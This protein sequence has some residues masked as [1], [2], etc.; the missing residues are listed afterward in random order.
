M[1]KVMAIILGA[2]FSIHC[3]DSN[4]KRISVQGTSE[5]MNDAV[6]SI[7]KDHSEILSANIIDNGFSLNGVIPGSDFYD[8]QIDVNSSPP[9]SKSYLMFLDGEECHISFANGGTGDYPVIES[10]SQVQKDISRFY[11]LYETKKKAIEKR[12]IVEQ[13]LV[14]RLQ[15]KEGSLLDF[16]NAVKTSNSSLLESVGLWDQSREVFI[17]QNSTSEL[18]AY[19]MAEMANAIEY[20]PLKYKALF[21]RFSNHVKRSKYGLASEKLI[22][23]FINGAA[24]QKV[25]E[26]FGKDVSNQGLNVSDLEG[27]ISLIL[28]WQSSNRESQKR[29][30]MLQDLYQ[31]YY[32]QG[33]EVVSI[34]FDSK[35]ETWE[36]YS[37]ANNIPWKN[38]YDETGVASPNVKNFGNTNIPYSFLIGPDLIISERDMPLDQFDLYFRTLKWQSLDGFKKLR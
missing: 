17:K 29:I 37:K 10:N 28:F 1:K 32:P 34:C 9:E 26:I 18:S 22:Q 8:L 38:L 27:K 5:G 30:K 4:Y 24:G 19:F 31:K 12:I 11:N 2:T 3:S 15:S 7:Q 23:K 21:A 36:N 13:K 33:F 35:K 16:N 20:D 14:D 6:I 25:S